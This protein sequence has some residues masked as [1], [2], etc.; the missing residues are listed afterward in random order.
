[1]AARILV[2]AGVVALLWATGLLELNLPWSDPLFVVSGVTVAAYL[3]W[4]LAEGARRRPGTDPSQLAMYVVLL[5]SAVDAFLLEIT[6]FESP[7]AIRWAGAVLFAA[8]AGARLAAVYGG[9]KPAL[10]RWGRVLQL[11]GL[12][13]GVGSLA[14]AAV[15]AV[16]GTVAALRTDESK[17]F[18]RGER[19]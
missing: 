4:S 14:G 12:P 5:V 7:L 9:P 3:L 15:G 10:L 13:L 6:L 2:L 11:V 17:A 8:G 16:P 19:R 18:G 1:L